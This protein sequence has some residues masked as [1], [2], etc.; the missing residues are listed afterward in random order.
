MSI[1]KVN[2]VGKRSKAIVIPHNFLEYWERQ[3]K[4]FTEMR[5]NISEDMATIVLAPILEDIEEGKQ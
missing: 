5:V 4:V 1:Q 3:G 2:T